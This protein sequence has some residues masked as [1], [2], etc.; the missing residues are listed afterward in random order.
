M[1]MRKTKESTQ[2]KPL[3][4]EYYLESRGYPLHCWANEPL[5]PSA[6][7]EDILNK[8]FAKHFPPPPGFEAEDVK[9]GRG[10]KVKKTFTVSVGD[11]KIP[12]TPEDVEAIAAKRALQTVIDD[13]SVNF[14]TPP[15]LNNIFKDSIEEFIKHEEEE[16]PKDIEAAIRKRTNDNLRKVFG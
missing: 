6:L 9:I 12:S 2:P 8:H 13:C 4:L 10:W 5:P 15:N 14:P 7:T 16:A 3:G 1:E 11:T